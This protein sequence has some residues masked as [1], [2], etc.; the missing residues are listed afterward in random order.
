MKH[1]EYHLQKQICQWLEYQHPNVLFLSD[2]VASVRLTIPQQVR[3]KGIQKKGFACPDILIL[4]P[5]GV[6]CGLFLELK[7]DSPLK[8]DGALKKSDHLERQAK[9]LREL[10]NKGYYARF[11]WGFEMTKEIITDYLNQ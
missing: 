2:T 8:K 11:S 7:V 10:S 3:N 1:P 9:S 4:E 5:R 6:F